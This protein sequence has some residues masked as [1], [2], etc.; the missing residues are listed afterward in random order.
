[1]MSAELNSEKSVSYQKKDG[2]GHACPSFFW[3]DNDKD[4]KVYFLV[5]RITRLLRF[6]VNVVTPKDG[7]AGG[8]PLILATLKPVI[9]HCP[10]IAQKGQGARLMQAL[11]T[12]ENTL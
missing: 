3:Y 7:L 2:R 12:P 4:L 8:A 1:M 5:T 6:L 11:F 9:L 10:F